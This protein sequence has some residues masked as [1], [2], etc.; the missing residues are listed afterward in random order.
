MAN[1]NKKVR[2][3]LKNAHYAIWNNGDGETEGSYAAPVAI[4]GSVSLSMNREGDTSDFYADDDVWASF[5]VNNG[6]SGD[7]EIAVVE[8]QLLIDLLGYVR[9]DNGVLLEPTDAE[10]V[11]FALLFEQ[12]GNKDKEA[13]VFYNCTLSR[14]ETAANTKSDS[15]DPDTA[16]LNIRMSGKELPWE[17]GTRTFIKGQANSKDQKAKFDAWYTQVQMPSKAAA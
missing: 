16:T 17:G 11:E 7:L 2:F 6:Y 12:G 15:T 4:P 9:D 1:V 3:G 14:P 13:Y 8:D 5:D 10:S